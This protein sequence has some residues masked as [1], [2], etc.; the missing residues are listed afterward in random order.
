MIFF[1]QFDQNLSISLDAILKHPLI[2]ERKANEASIDGLLAN[3]AEYKLEKSI[4]HVE[5]RIK[6][7]RNIIVFRDLPNDQKSSNYLKE[8]L[9]S[10]SERSEIKDIEILTDIAIVHFSNE[11]ST[12]EVFDKIEALKLSH[13]QSLNCFI[14]S[15]NL[16]LKMFEQM[17]REN[18]SLVQ[19]DNTITIGGYSVPLASNEKAKQTGDSIGNML[20]PTFSR[21]D[22]IS[23]KDVSKHGSHFR[24]KFDME[25]NHQ[26]T[27]K[28]EHIPLNKEF[29]VEISHTNI[30]S[31]SYLK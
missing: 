30:G 9:D 15:D 14:K 8:L 1:D 25:S 12:L 10:V 5:K 27:D 2:L 11:Q 6:P 22:T 16:K 23:K 28:T 13:S 19:E 29:P 26:K 18:P 31:S 24:N 20:D 4:R 21:I 17:K 3:S 7:E